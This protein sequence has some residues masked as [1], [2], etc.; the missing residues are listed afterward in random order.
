MSQFIEITGTFGPTGATAGSPAPFATHE[1]NFGLGG[2]MQVADNTERNA[3][4]ADRRSQ[5]MAVY[6]NADNKLYVL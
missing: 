1:A 2:Y 6:V 5:G 3:I 4:T